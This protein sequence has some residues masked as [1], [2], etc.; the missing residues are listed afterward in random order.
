M[1]I[2][3][4]VK[5]LTVSCSSVSNTYKLHSTNMIV[6]IA[7]FNRGEKLKTI[8]EILAKQL[9]AQSNNTITIPYLYGNSVHRKYN[10]SLVLLLSKLGLSHLAANYLIS[11]KFD[12]TPISIPDSE[13]E[14]FY[15]AFNILNQV[16][17]SKE[18][19]CQ[20]TEIYIFDWREYFI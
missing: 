9:K 13:I 17:N 10:L 1:M 6:E 4:F 3:S 16:Y 14:R 11:S 5:Y 8:E 7:W 20:K 2:A 18:G 15:I 19:L 12:S